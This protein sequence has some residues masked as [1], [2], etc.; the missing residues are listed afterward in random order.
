MQQD[1][2]VIP[3]D[4]SRMEW[5]GDFFWCKPRRLRPSRVSFLSG[6]LSQA[7]GGGRRE[8]V[9]QVKAVAREARPGS[10]RQLSPEGL[11]LQE[12][13]RTQVLRLRTPPGTSQCRDAKASLCFLP[14]AD[15]GVW[16]E[17]PVKTAQCG[18]KGSLSPSH[19][20]GGRGSSF[21]LLTASSPVLWKHSLSGA[22]K[23]RRDQ[24]SEKELF[25]FA[26]PP[27]EGLLIP[28]D[29]AISSSPS[30]NC[31]HSSRR[32]PCR[33]AVPCPSPPC[34]PDLAAS[35]LV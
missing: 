32:F 33:P 2:P 34:A 1:I 25:N 31:L 15:L 19:F 22:G 24:S 16:E 3:Q 35:F 13:L 18:S 27:D 20:L 30:P 23:K 7:Y 9:F 21:L 8:M 11:S 26:N 10:G 29:W 5:K 17:S 14:S 12:E 4:L 6:E 28:R